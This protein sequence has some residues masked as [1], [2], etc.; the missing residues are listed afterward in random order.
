MTDV[1][2]SKEYT[3]SEKTVQYHF[4][5]SVGQL[6]QYAD[7]SLTI[8]IVDDQ[9]N[10]FHESKLNGWRKIVVPGNEASKDIRVF[11][12]VVE[13]LIKFEADRKT[14]LIGI[15]GGVITDLTGFVASVYMRGVPYAFVPTTLLSQVDAAIGGKNG[16]NY[17]SYKNM[18]GV[19][20]QPE[21][22]LFDDE[23]LQTLPEEEWHNG[24]AEII[25][26]ACICDAAL[27]DFLEENRE[28][29][30]LGN[31]EVIRELVMRSADIK[32]VIVRE[33]EF[34]NGQRRL[35]NFG[36]TIG[37]AVEKLEGIA[38]GQ[39]VAKG[40]VAATEFSEILSGL[41]VEDKQRIR[42]LIEHYHLPVTINSDPKAI[43][44]HFRMDKKR[45]GQAIHFIL[46]EKIGH[47]VIKALS[48][49]QL[50]GLLNQVI[51]VKEVK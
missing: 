15:G 29:A 17:G 8:L 27:F 41:Q 28:K 5:S 12:K 43:A 48:L 34:E 26:Y 33:D 1:L 49:D 18:L 45:E 37:H 7:P 46:L 19:I 16:I 23:L 14:N 35:L 39:A 51:K 4:G 25:K 22:L 20:R 44:H 36:H 9:V 6:D 24:F 47:A 21:F 42:N 32:S 50:S 31:K 30:L 38:H 40:M 11:G 13:E 2:K 10:R 3:F